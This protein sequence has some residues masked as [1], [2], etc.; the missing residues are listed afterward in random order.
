MNGLQTTTQVLLNYIGLL[1]ERSSNKLLDQ[2][3]LIKKLL[4]PA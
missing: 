2:R 1:A 4:L 3:S